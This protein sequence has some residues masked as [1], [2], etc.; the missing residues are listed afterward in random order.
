MTSP[1]QKIRMKRPI[2]VVRKTGIERSL[3]FMM[4]TM[5]VMKVATPGMAASGFGC[6]NANNKMKTMNN[7][8]DHFP[9]TLVGTNNF[10]IYG[11]YF[12]AASASFAPSCLSCCSRSLSLAACPGFLASVVTWPTQCILHSDA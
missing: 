5:P 8:I 10:F 1:R 9:S 4:A 12:F 2:S 11:F 6:T 7:P 3:L